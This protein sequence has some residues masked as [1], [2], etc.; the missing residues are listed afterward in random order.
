M[1]G[2]DLAIQKRKLWR[3][4]VQPMRFKTAR[5][6]VSLNPVCVRKLQK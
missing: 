5:E 3:Q 2:W 1:R 4:E 6:A